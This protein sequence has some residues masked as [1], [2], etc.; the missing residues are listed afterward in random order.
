MPALAVWL[1]GLGAAL[2]YVG[3]SMAGLHR[4][5]G[6]NGLYYTFPWWDNVVHFLGSWAVGAAAAALLAAPPAGRFRLRVALA[7]CVGVT[8]GVAVEVYEF[9]QFVLWGTVDQGFYTN[10]V[11][12]LY[13]NALG[14]CAGAFVYVRL[15]L[16]RTRPS[17]RTTASP[18][19]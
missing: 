8:V 13:Y 7:A 11:L 3:G 5:G 19:R 1:V 17:A 12:D 6:P 9:L 15:E 18:L 4:V 10:T 2:H 16:S 14:A